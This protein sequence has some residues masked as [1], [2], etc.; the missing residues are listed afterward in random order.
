MADSS[1]SGDLTSIM[2]NQTH[3]DN[4]HQELSQKWD[5][6]AAADKA[7]CPLAM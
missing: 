2:G 4:M 5:A 6:A 1:A 7:L 3:R